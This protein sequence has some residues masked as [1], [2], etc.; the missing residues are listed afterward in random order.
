MDSSVGETL[1]VDRDAEAAVTCRIH[2]GW[3]KFQ[4]LALFLAAED[5]FEASWE[6][7]FCIHEEQYAGWE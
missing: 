2:S 3:C 7:L 1:G 4:S 5:V 6:G